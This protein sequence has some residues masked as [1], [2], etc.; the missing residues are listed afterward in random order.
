[1]ASFDLWID[2]LLKAEGGFAAADNTAGAVNFGLTECFMREHNIDLTSDG[3]VD[4]QDVKALTVDEAKAIYRKYFWDAMKL[5]QII[6]QTLANLLGHMGVNQGTGTSVGFLQHA[7]VDCGAAIPE[8]GIIGA[9][10]VAA[11]NTMPLAA[12]YKL[13]KHYALRR[14]VGL[15][16]KNPA[17]YGDDLK[18]W[19]LRLKSL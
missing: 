19:Y 18:G 16:I 14:Y 2:G 15:A 7:L 1:V 10:T 17:Q 4:V 5:D 6:S 3:K 12:V 11:A 13:V 8:D 9:L